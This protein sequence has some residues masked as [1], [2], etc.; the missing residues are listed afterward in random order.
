MKAEIKPT[1]KKEV[2][3]RNLKPRVKQ[4]EEREND[5]RVED[6]DLE[7]LEKVPGIKEYKL[8]GEKRKGLGGSPVDEKAYIKIESKRDVAEAFLA[9][10]SGLD[11]VVVKNEREWDL[12]MLRKYNPSIKEVSET[13]EV[14]GIDKAVNMEGFE[15]AGIKLEDED[16][17]P[18]YQQVV[19]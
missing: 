7:F 9:T 1:E 6:S 16:I 19:R 8:D 14:L 12:K 18:V 17:D 4:L 13:N 11:L 15:D 2:L 10:A 3:A 5:I